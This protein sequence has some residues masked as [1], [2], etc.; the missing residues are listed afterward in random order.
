MS[1]GDAAQLREIA[2]LRARLAREV[3]EQRRALVGDLIELIA[4][5]QH[6]AG[7]PGEQRQRAHLLVGELVEAVAQQDAVR[8]GLPE[9]AVARSCALVWSR[10]SDSAE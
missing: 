5:H 10:S 4:G 1:Q 9:D 8:V 6:A 3:G 2:R 7:E